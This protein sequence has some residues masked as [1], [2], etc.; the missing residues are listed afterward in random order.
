VSVTL[1]NLSSAG[2]RYFR[3]FSKKYNTRL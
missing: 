1:N 2:E 3:V